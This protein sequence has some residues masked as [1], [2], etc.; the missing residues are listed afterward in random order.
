MA[1]L[2]FFNRAE[3]DVHQRLGDA[4]I[5]EIYDR[6]LLE[7]EGKEIINKFL[8]R[9]KANDLVKNKDLILESIEQDINNHPEIEK[10]RRV[11]E[12]IAGLFIYTK[13]EYPEQLKQKISAIPKRRLE[14][15]NV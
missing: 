11:I 10:I 13:Q 5:Q 7:E 15:L 4:K 9:I 14:C 12:D 2:K 6:H 1:R 3:S 8:G